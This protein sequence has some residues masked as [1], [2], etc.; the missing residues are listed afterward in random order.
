MGQILT[1]EQAR[2][3]ARSSNFNVEL[4]ADKLVAQYKEVLQEAL[5]AE[6]DDELGYS[7]HDWKNK[8]N[9]NSRNGHSKKTVSS[10]FGKIDLKISRNTERNFEPVTVKT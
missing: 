2:E 4:M 8:I 9:Q 3:I 5:E 10:R 1:K 7:K 6:M